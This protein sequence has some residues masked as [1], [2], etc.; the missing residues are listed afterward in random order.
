MK[1]V[2]S[3]L[4]ERANQLAGRKDDERQESG[5]MISVIEFVLT[6]EIYAV[7]GV[8]VTEVLALKDITSIPGT[9]AFVMGVINLRG[10]IISILNLKTL[11]NLKE[12]GLTELNKIII[13]K[14]DHMEF[15]IVADSIV[16]TKTLARSSVSP[17]PV[18]L[19]TIGH[20]FI[21]GVTQDG[22]ILL[23]ALNLLTSKKIQSNHSY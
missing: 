23:N 10:R 22:L 1:D 7:E 9:P 8:F 13:L 3:I 20:E 6:P 19:D 4:V 21:T 2:N 18:T 12:R 14:S 16:G 17:P 15:G 5:E 11:F